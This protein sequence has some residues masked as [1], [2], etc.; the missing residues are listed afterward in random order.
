MRQ[1]DRERCGL[2]WRRCCNRAAVARRRATAAAGTAGRRPT[3][4]GAASVPGRCS[5]GARRTTAPSPRVRFARIVRAS[6][7]FVVSEPP[8]SREWRYRS[9]PV[10]PAAPGRVPTPAWRRK[11]GVVAADAVRAGVRQQ[12][13]ERCG[14]LWRRCWNRRAAR[15]GGNGVAAALTVRRG[16]DHAAFSAPRCA[17]LPRRRQGAIRRQYPQNRGRLLAGLLVHRNL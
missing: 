10:R 15:A 12:D 9:D 16:R 17:E 2:R 1:Q 13:R 6:F 4:C 5:G 8:P 14:R 11:Y 3:S 7:A